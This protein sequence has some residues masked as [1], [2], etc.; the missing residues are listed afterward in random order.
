[1]VGRGICDLSAF[2][3]GGQS[4]IVTVCGRSDR[5]WNRSQSSSEVVV[6]ASPIAPIGNRNENGD[7]SSQRD[8]IYIY[9]KTSNKPPGDLNFQTLKHGE[10]FGFL[11]LE[12]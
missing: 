4:T 3:V 11:Y 7:S 6:K 1:M 10:K 2:V 12:S 9:R 8:E 5:N